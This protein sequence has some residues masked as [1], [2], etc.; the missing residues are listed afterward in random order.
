MLSDVGGFAISMVSIKIGKLNPT[1]QKSWGFH[2]AE[3]L[4]AITSILVIWAMIIWL[5]WEA[6]ERIMNIHSHDHEIDAPIML[7]TA[8]VSL[9]CNL[10]SLSALGHL[11][12]PACCR[13]KTASG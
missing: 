5:C 6:T 13:K 4:G 9:I 7:I 2:R 11:P 10:I 1:F 3:V 8:F 12:L